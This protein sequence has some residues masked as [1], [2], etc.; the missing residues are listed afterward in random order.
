MNTVW[1]IVARLACEAATGVLLALLLRFFVC[2]LVRV[3]GRSM[4]DTLHNGDFMLALR[5][6]LFG[7]IRRFDVVICRYPGRKGHFV[8][9]VVGLPGERVSMTE[10]ALYING[11][12]VTEDFPL[13]RSL[14]GFD[15]RTLG[16]DEYFV[17]G[18]NRPCSS[19]SRR[20]GPIH[21]RAI[22][23]RVCCVFL[24]LRRRQRI[25]RG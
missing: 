3:K 7:R 18:D 16:P 5:Y 22:L 21:R 11:A 6:G 13:R 17:M 4:Q 8:K 9:R 23:A 14:R 1:H 24:P 2:M 25:R 15:E 19:D 10:G 20:V 12:E